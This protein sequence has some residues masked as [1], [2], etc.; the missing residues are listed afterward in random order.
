VWRY[1]GEE[2]KT[3]QSNTVRVLRRTKLIAGV[4]CRVV[5]DQVFKHGR[6]VEDTHDWFAQ[7]SHGTVWYYGERTRELDRNGHVTS[8]EGSWRAGLH[9][10]KPGIIMPAHP[11]VGFSARQEYYKGHAEDHFKIIR[12]RVSVNVP[13]RH[14]RKRALLTREWTPLEPGVIDHKYYVRGLGEVA[15]VTVKGGHEVG[16][17]VSISHR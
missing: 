6:V 8:R 5:H 2:G 11:R 13:Y 12:R 16:K 14:F 1:R 4:R 7:D 17:L 3:P 9:G 15:E 10:A